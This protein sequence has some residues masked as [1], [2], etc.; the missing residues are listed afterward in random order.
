MLSSSTTAN[1]VSISVHPEYIKYFI[2]F[3]MNGARFLAGDR[4]IDPTG[5]IGNVIQIFADGHAIV[6]VD[7]FPRNVEMKTDFLLRLSK[8]A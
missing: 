7:G 1:S 5:N 8:L 3:D 6:A 2:S 4:F